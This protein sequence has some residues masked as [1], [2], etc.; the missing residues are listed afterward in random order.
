MANGHDHSPLVGRPVGLSDNRKRILMAA[1]RLLR[2]G[3]VEAATLR[4]ICDE[5]KIKAPTLYHYYGD[6]RGVYRAVIEEVIDKR[7]GPASTD[8]A[9]P[10][11]RLD[12]IWRAH[13][14]IATNEPGLFDLWSRQLAWDRLSPTSIRSERLLE[15]AFE[16]LAQEYG[17]KASPAVAAWVFWAAA[18]GLASLIAA[19]RHEGGLPYPPGSAETLKQ[20]VLG[21]LFERPPF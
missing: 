18:H 13:I 1:L 17:L 10:L 7:D 16:Q 19:S 5:A 12:D 14:Q 15:N 20:G 2:E 4:A 11:E 21:S 6:M 9:A 8:T 3:G